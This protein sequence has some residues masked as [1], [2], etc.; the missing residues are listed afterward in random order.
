MNVK[1]DATRTSSAEPDV[2][3]PLSDD[4]FERGYGAMLARRARAATGLSE[5]EYAE[6]FGIPIVT[7]H[8]WEAGKEAPGDPATSY[9]RV[10]V[11]MPEAVAR[12]LHDA[13]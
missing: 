6:C 5:E 13:A 12:A 11:Q 10:I 9:L 7:L 3:A 2:D 1:Q 8:A 4:E